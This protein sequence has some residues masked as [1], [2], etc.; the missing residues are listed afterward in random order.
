[1]AGGPKT[2]NGGGAAKPKRVVL[3][4]NQ[5][6]RLKK[7]EKRAAAASE[8][9]APP[10]PPPAPPKKENVVVEYVSAAYDA[11]AAASLFKDVFAKFASAEELTTDTV[12]EVA[13]DAPVAEK[14][15]DVEEDE[16]PEK[17]L[18]R[19]QRK[20]MSRMTVAELKQVVARPEAVEAHDVTASDPRLLVFLKSYRNTVPVPRHWC[21]KRKFLQGKRGVE[22]K[23]FQLPEYIAQT[24]LYTSVIFVR[25]TNL[26]SK[27]V[28]ILERES[29][30]SSDS[31]DELVDVELANAA[32]RPQAVT[33]IEMED[34]AS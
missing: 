12:E 19:K 29:S 18:S 8:P 1:M 32:T 23:P 6:K 5:K 13:T 11:D 21:H 34:I 17:R 31:P 28:K 30:S 22:K 3:T 24:G 33:T 14:A 27:I 16:A 26:M 15:D 20:A 4:K 9:A 25:P 7:K 2:N 10:V